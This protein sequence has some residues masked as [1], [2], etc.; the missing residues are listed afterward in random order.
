MNPYIVIVLILLILQIFIHPISS[1]TIPSDRNIPT[2]STGVER[3]AISGPSSQKIESIMT[4]GGGIEGGGI[5]TERTLYL[6]SKEDPIQIKKTVI[7]NGDNGYHAG[8]IVGVF[9]E[10]KNMGQVLKHVAIKEFVD[11]DGDIINISKNCYIL[12][13]LDEI[14]DYESRMN[15]DY[16]SD[17]D[18]GSG[19][20]NGSIHY[21]D[22]LD[23]QMGNGDYLF[24][25]IN[26]KNYKNNIYKFTCKNFGTQWLNLTINKTKDAQS[27]CIKES[28]NS[29]KEINITLDRKREYAKFKLDNITYKCK[30]NNGNIYKLKNDFGINI[31]E[32][33]SKQRLAYWY[34]VKL[35]KPGDFDFSTIARYWINEISDFRDIDSSSKIKVTNPMPNV[36]T[37]INKLHLLNNEK[38][39]LSYNITYLNRPIDNIVKIELK[40]KSYYTILEQSGPNYYTYPRDF[41][42][43]KYLDKTIE[44]SYPNDGEYFLPEII[45]DGINYPFTNEKVLVETKAQKNANL[46][47]IIIGIILFLLGDLVVRYRMKNGRGENGNTNNQNPCRESDVLIAVLILFISAITI[48]YF[49]SDTYFDIP[50]LILLIASFTIVIIIL[51]FLYKLLTFQ[52]N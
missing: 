28:F 41:S 18:D 1:I 21:I 5:I 47:A 26:F 27:I 35:N 32:L 19:N 44:I 10:A 48:I 39:R 29:S 7:P 38:I 30:F 24:D 16:Y 9:V 13:T 36:N 51:Y 12:D 8:D 52:L 46:V 45:I 50:F 2:V 37:D 49:L 17:L 33:G 3:F 43:G 14:S 23:I 20:C 4:S 40:K 6:P 15:K 22:L 34:Y 42:M 11:G 25:L 31:N